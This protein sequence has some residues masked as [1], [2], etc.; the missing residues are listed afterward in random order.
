[1]RNWGSV[2]GGAFLNAFFI[3]FDSISDI[4]RV[5]Q[6]IFSVMQEDHVPNVQMSMTVAAVAAISLNLS[7]QMHMGTSVSLE[8]L[9][10]MQQGNVK[11]YARNHKG[12]EEANHALDFTGML[13]IFCWFRLWVSSATLSYKAKDQ[14]IQIGS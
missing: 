12:S 13:L 4:F 9:I 11:L 7:A 14:L 5:N 3:I 6:S 10:A 1:M 8:S 2:A